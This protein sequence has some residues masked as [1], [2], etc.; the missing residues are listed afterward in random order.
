MNRQLPVQLAQYFRPSDRRFTCTDG[1]VQYP[2]A[3]PT[4]VLEANRYYFS[5]PVWAQEYFDACHRDETFKER[6]A[7]A[8]GSWDGKVVVDIGC[9]PG[10]LYA[11]LGGN[12]SLLIGVDISAAALQM[13]KQL[14]YTPLLADAHDL[15]LRS[16]FADVVVLNATLHHC[17]DMARVLAEAA[18]LVKPNGLLV[19]DCDP[20]KSAWHFRGFG[21]V[22]VAPE[23]AT[24]SAHWARRTQVYRAAALVRGGRSASPTGIWPLPPSVS[25]G[26]PAFRV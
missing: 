8:L 1:I 14:G 23:I 25:P 20:Q 11:T 17:D 16:G 19:T 10:N 9:G 2:I 21:L 12:P 18:R 22:A 13:A 3:N 4:A 26:P 6:W 24:V 5:H 7:A 15:P